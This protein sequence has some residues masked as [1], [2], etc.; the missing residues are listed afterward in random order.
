MEAVRSKHL[1]ESSSIVTK[2]RFVQI[3]YLAFGALSIIFGLSALLFPSMVHPAKP[4][5]FPFDHDLRELGAALVGI[6]LVTLWCIFNY[7]RS[8]MINYILTLFNLFIAAIHWYDYLIGNLPLTSPLFN[9][10]G[11]VLFTV[12]SIARHR[13]PAKPAAV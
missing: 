1:P 9:S 8:R 7:E 11:F 4:H 10:L 12:I 6:G 5:P 2:K 3:G 13:E